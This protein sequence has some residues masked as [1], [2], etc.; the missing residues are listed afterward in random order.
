MTHLGK[1]LYF[2]LKIRVKKYVSHLQQQNHLVL[3]NI[4]VSL[5]T[6]NTIFSCSSLENGM[7][8]IAYSFS[9]SLLRQRKTLPKTPSPVEGK[10]R[11]DY[12]KRKHI[13]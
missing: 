10:V 4:N 1:N 12:K 7:T 8:L 11:F 3:L 2:P 6:H 13:I 9:S 5:K